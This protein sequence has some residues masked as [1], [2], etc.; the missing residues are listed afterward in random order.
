MGH[1]KDNAQ[2]IL[3][4]QS[5]TLGANHTDVLTESSSQNATPA[6]ALIQE[7]DLNSTATIQEEGTA[8]PGHTSDPGP[9]IMSILLMR[10]GQGNVL[11]ALT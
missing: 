8:Q 9:S 5:Q 1:Q 3:L 4:R 6:G 2:L 7:Q 10:I 11:N